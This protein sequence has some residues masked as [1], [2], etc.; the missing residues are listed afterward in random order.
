MKQNNKLNIIFH[1]RYPY[2]AAIIA[3]M[4]I[5]MSIIILCEKSSEYELLIGLTA[6]STL[7]IAVL[8]FKSPK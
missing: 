1:T 8:G 6:I 7:I 4:W 2:T 3:I 5:G